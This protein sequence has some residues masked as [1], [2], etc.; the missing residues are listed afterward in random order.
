VQ[1]GHRDRGRRWGGGVV[2]CRIARVALLATLCGAAVPSFAAP[3]DEFPVPPDLAPAVRFWVDVFTRYSRDDFVIHDR[4]ELGRVYEVV[5][6]VRNAGEVAAEAQRIADRVAL[7]GLWGVDPFER[8][9]RPGLEARAAALG[10]GRVRVQRGMREVFAAGLLG[11]RRYRRIVERA[12]EQE[13]LPRAL[14]ALPLV[15]SSYNPD[16]TSSAGAAGIWQLTAETGQRFLR[17]SERVDERRDPVRA[18]QAAARLLRSLHDALPAWPLAVTAY[19]HGLAGVERARRAVGSDDLG[20]L[21]TRYAGPGFGFASRN[22]YAEFVAASQVL[23]HVE[24]YFP[25]IAPDRIIEYQVKRGDSLFK[26]AR[27]HGITV[28]KLCATN[29]LRSAKLQPGQVLLIRL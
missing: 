16:A 14:A 18:T 28:P 12:L 17:V 5:R 19:N 15:E 20:V 3:S 10:A 1:W 9:L 11:A 2:R 4:L 8:L 21:V 23:R 24:R 25:E 13:G 7:Q 26:V 6:G 27:R 29:G 22:F